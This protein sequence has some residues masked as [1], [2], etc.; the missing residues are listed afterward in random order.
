MYRFS[1]I[2]YS[3]QRVMITWQDFHFAISRPDFSLQLWGDKKRISNTRTMLALGESSCSVRILNVILTKNEES[4]VE[5]ILTYFCLLLFCSL[6]LGFRI[7]RTYYYCR[8]G[9]SCDLLS[10]R[11]FNRK[12]KELDMKSNPVSKVCN[13]ITRFRLLENCRFAF[14]IFY[15]TNQAP[16]LSQRSGIL[17]IWFKFFCL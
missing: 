2:Q 15:R 9:R 4:Q 7:Y 14:A 13:F 8:V 5:I 11:Q 10:F 1:F 17:F 16:F 12:K 3:S 6:I